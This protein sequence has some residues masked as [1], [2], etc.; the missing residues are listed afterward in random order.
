MTEQFRA[1]DERDLDPNTVKQFGKWYDDVLAANIP[2]ADAVTVA[3]ATRDGNPS[4]RVVLLK[5]F[6]DHGFVFFTNYNSRKAKQLSENPRASMV[7]YWPAPIKRQVR[8]E[9]TVEKVSA[10]ESESYFQ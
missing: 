7:A 3:T 1:L 10:E 5:S 2:E 9:G 4:A 6:D 8:I